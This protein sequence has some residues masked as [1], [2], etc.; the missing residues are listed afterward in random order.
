MPGNRTDFVGLMGFSLKRSKQ[1]NTARL[2]IR[3][4]GETHHADY[5]TSPPSERNSG[6]TRELV[7]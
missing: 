1:K 3:L 6:A 4:K 2:S 7:S 5:G